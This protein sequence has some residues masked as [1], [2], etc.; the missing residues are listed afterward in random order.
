[1]GIPHE[2]A[3][4]CEDSFHV[5][6]DETADALSLRLEQLLHA[7]KLGDFDDKIRQLGSYGGGNHF[8]ECEVVSIADS[9]HARAAAETFGLRNNCVAFLSHC[10]SRGLGHKL[11][12][13]QFR[14]LQEHFSTWSIPLPGNDRELVYAPLGTP[15]ADAY[16]D[17]MALGANFAT[18]NHLLINA[19]V[20]DAFQEILPGTKGDLVYFISH[21]IA[22]KEIVDN[23]LAWVHRKGATRAFPANHAGL[24]GTPF[25]STG[26][27][28][29]LPGNPREG[30]VV[31]VPAEGAAKSCF[32]VNHG[33]GRRM[34]RKDAIRRLDQAAI[35]QELD[36]CDILSN[37]RQYPKDEV[38]DAYKDFG[39]V[40]KS[41]E[42]AGLAT[43]VA[44]LKARFVIKDGDKAD[45]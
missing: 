6:H 43:P 39:E 42:L 33:A 23:R 10:G 30:S 22:R 24:K 34:G 15:H 19:L 8:G 32:S 21:N 28:I 1:M 44:N 31:M 11:A 14:S 18:V 7:E 5:G 37:C 25:E 35:D 9:D 13:G 12:A 38:P 20:L 3:A 2:W 45:D 17:D 27:P 36:Q 29:L 26:H 40:L 41:V 4:R 16:L